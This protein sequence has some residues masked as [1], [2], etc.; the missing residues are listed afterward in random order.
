MF[1]KGEILNCTF[2]T[3]ANLNTLAAPKDIY[4]YETYLDFEK[5]IADRLRN[6]GIPEQYI[7]GFNLDDIT[8]IIDY[9]R[10]NPVVD[11]SIRESLILKD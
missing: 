10:I 3:V 5:E 11:P 1:R 2:I 6:I 8:N 7:S 4:F 9:L